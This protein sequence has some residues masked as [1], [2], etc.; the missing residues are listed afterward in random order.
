MKNK[1]L[2]FILFS[3]ICL[4]QLSSKTITDMSNNKIVVP[5]KIERVFGSAPP[6]TFLISLYKPDLLVGLNFPS[7]NMN[8]FGDSYYLGEK[9]M[10]LKS[11]GGWQGSQK[12]ASVE[13]LLKLKTQI[14]LGWNND[15]LL[16]K[17]NKSLNNINIP[18]VMVNGDD[19]EKMPETF[20][21]LG[22]L[23]DMPKRGEELAT[24]AQNSL[25]Y[26]SNMTKNIE[27]GKEVT[28]YY[29]E[30]QNGLTSDCTYSFHTTQFRY[31]HAKNI[32][33]C[34]QKDIMGMESI[35]FESIL[36]ADPDVIIVQSPKFYTNIFKNPKWKMLKAV[37][38]KK[39]Y[40][41]PRIPF[42]WI[43]R[44]PSFMRLL[45]IHWLSS[46]MYPQYYKKDINEEIK[47]FYKI[48][49]KV[50]LDEEKLKEIKKRAF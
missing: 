27:K 31:I 47:T 6:T 39:V 7:F 17:M 32:Y 21:F 43:D 2:F 19:L 4:T 50:D 1:F 5:D 46:V 42:N 23:F 44:P 45:G 48:F 30:G 25:E 35:N 20:E 15:F 29:A 8:N 24:Y 14:I 36:K 38:A 18:T 22:N 13:M 41:V 40:L 26:I 28:F 10:N 37:K 34:Q 9:F 16:K 11:L 49:F 3:F 33:E 12:G